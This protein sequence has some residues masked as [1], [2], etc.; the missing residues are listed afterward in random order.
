[1]KPCPHGRWVEQ[2]FAGAITPHD[3]RVLRRHLPGCEDCRGLYQRLLVGSR[4]DPRA[5]TPKER[6]ARGLGLVPSPPRPWVAIVAA[7]V[8]LTACVLLA[9]AC[10]T[11]APNA[12]GALSQKTRLR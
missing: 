12:S 1:M 7:L 3:E 6:L 10:A 11:A 4:L 5:L 8:A 2:H 9:R